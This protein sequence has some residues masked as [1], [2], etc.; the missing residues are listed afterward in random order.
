MGDF[1]RRVKKLE[2]NVNPTED[3][4]TFVF[5]EGQTEADFERWKTE[6]LEG[7]GNPNVLFVVVT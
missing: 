6:Y 5:E 3:V 7:G 2:E 4:K 1:E